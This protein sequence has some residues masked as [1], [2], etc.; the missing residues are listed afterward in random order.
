MLKSGRC[1]NAELPLTQQRFGLC[2][3]M[4]VCGQLEILGFRLLT[5]LLGKSQQVWESRRRRE[6]L[7]LR[8][9]VARLGTQG[10]L[11]T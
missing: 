6:I 5:A 7:D 10:D 8:L 1:L 11:G 4:Y 9:L 3:A 2:V